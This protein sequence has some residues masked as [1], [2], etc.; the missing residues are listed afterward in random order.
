M[1]SVPFDA[2][3]PLF[4]T[5]SAAVSFSGD[6]GEFFRLVRNGALLELVTFEAEWASLK[7]ICN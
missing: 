5:P 6:R 4:T 2:R 3:Q 1:S 7:A